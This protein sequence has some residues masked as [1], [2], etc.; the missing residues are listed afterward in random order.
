[1]WVAVVTGVAIIYTITSKR[2][3]VSPLFPVTWVK[4][5]NATQGD[6]S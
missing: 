3:P 4:S 1:M 6:N 2:I 5:R